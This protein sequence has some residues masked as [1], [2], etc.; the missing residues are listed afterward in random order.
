MEI[1]ADA[2][3]TTD[4]ALRKQTLV[5]SAGVITGLSV[6]WV[7]SYWALGLPLSAAIPFAYQVISVINLA[8]FART[9][10]YRFFRASELAL[11]ILLPFALQ[12]SLGGFVPSSGVIL[13]SFTA[14]LGALLF[15]GRREA[16]RWFV[17]FLAVVAV[18]GI[19]DPLLP[20]KTDQIPGW[21][22]VTFFVLNVIGVTGTCYVLLHF[23]V[24]ERDQAFALVAQE[25][26]RS[27]R[28]LLNVLP[29]PIA[30]RL[31]GGES[32]IADA[33]PE[34][35]VLFADIAGFT[36]MSAAMEPADLVRLLDDIFTEFDALADKHGLEKIKT[37]GDAYMV[38][39]G[40]LDR[41]GAHANDLALM[42]LDM[43]DAV[44]RRDGLELRIGID[45][46]PVVAGVIGRRKF[47][48]DLWGDT[49]NTASR[50]ESH[51][52]AG[53]IHVTERTKL[54][55]GN[56]FR[57]EDRGVIEVKGKGP[58][59]TYLLRG[60]SHAGADAP[61]TALDSVE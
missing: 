14:P 32:V 44:G 5:L 7:V 58:M 19:L 45:I 1:G 46:G 37:I 26:E 34:V 57:F 40:L 17:A 55:L 59:H 9:R 31:K 4:E 22:V 56:R 47:I 36:P 15:A 33:A 10:R 18:A 20:Q 38:A 42:A 12:L 11:S 51:G 6:V 60:R 21:V 41:Q 3:D 49:V 8:V 48:Y 13:W 28:L 2:S 52:T 35:G 16:L 27:E 30:E 61:S 23:F 54:L 53:A 24:R 39:S 50:M 43:L 29:G 25:R